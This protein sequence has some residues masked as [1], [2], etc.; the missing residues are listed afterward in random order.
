M[1]EHNKSEIPYEQCQTAQ[2]DVNTINAAEQHDHRMTKLT[3]QLMA[4]VPAQTVAHH[5]SGGI[6][7]RV[8]KTSSAATGPK[9]ANMTT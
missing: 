2:Q 9:V 3:G 4:T 7:I 6:R 8:P 1:V 5:F